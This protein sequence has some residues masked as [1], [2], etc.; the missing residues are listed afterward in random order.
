MTIDDAADEADGRGHYHAR[1]GWPAAIAVAAAAVLFLLA[2]MAGVLG[3]WAYARLAG[4]AA[5]AEAPGQMLSFLGTMQLAL[6]LLVLLAARAF[7][8]Q[9]QD[10]LA[11]VPSATG[12]RGYI[13]GLLGLLGLVGAMDAVM[14][15]LKPEPIMGDMKPFVGMIRSDL[16]WLTLLVVGIGAPLSEELLFR[17]FVQSALAQTRLG[18]LG[19]T[20]VTTSTWT[21]L[22]ANYSI[23]GIIQVGVI[24]LYLSWLLWRTGSLK[25][26]MFCHGAYNALMTLLIG[27]G[28]LPGA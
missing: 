24:G 13:Y 19:A 23:L 12:W 17:G 8:S 1:T 15:L 7:G 3:Q 14:L 5:A 4:G 9:A 25:V 26:T 27:L 21:A 6:V 20:L 11:L 16:W 22:H 28:P 10:V 2:S 18:F